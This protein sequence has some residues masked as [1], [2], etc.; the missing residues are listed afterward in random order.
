[1][2]EYPSHPWRFTTVLVTVKAMKKLTTAE[3][4][5]EAALHSSGKSS[6]L[7]TQGKGPIP[8]LKKN[9]NSMMDTCKARW[10]E[11]LCILDL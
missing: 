1:M 4:E 11:L 10:D 2:P 3:R 5:A 8:M 7:I 9:M 6:P